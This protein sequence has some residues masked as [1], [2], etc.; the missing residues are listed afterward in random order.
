MT[1]VYVHLSGKET[2]EDILKMSGVKIK[3]KEI[4]NKLTAKIC[5]RCNSKNTFNDKYCSKCWLPLDV[6]TAMDDDKKNKIAEKIIVKA[7]SIDR[8]VLKET[9]RDMIILFILFEPL[10]KDLLWK[11]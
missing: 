1:G 8:N 9:I 2:D 7:K 4:K 11:M 10:L 5:P 6:K 3:E